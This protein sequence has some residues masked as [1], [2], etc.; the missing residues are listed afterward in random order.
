MKFIANRHVPCVTHILILVIQEGMKSFVLPAIVVPKVEEDD[1]F[2]TTQNYGINEDVGM[3]E[4]VVEDLEASK[5]CIVSLGDVMSKV[6][7]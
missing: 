7:T 3:G 2:K 1:V 4:F 6:R 5:H